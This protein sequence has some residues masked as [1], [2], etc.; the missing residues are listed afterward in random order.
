MTHEQIEGFR[1]A[2]IRAK[3][4]YRRALEAGGT[5]AVSVSA[6][7]L[8]PI[9]TEAVARFSELKGLSETSAYKGKLHDPEVRQAFTQELAVRSTH[10]KDLLQGTVAQPLIFEQQADM[11]ELDAALAIDDTNRVHELQTRIN[12][13]GA[14]VEK[15]LR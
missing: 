14:E 11:R 8:K 7:E 2:N 15:M 9:P 6:N 1:E 13:L 10:I 3:L 12:T 5:P 4:E